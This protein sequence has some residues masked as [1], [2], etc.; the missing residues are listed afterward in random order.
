[1]DFEHVT[2]HVTLANIE[3]WANTSELDTLFFDALRDEDGDGFQSCVIA[4]CDDDQLLT[5]AKTRNSAK[6]Q[7]FASGLVER[8]VFHLYAPH[9]LPYEFS[10][11]AG[12]MPFDEYKAAELQRME[13]VY[14]RCRVVEDMRRSEQDEISNLGDMISTIATTGAAPR[15]AH[16]N[17]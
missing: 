3:R 7:F 15:P 5:F 8:L 12:L 14:A 9:H 16:P 13:N 4:A 6:R 2:K 11:T 17:F 1:M 10:R